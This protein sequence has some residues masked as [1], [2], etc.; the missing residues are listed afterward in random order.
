M[1]LVQRC[2]KDS[3]DRTATLRKLK[4]KRGAGG[5]DMSRVRGLLAVSIGVASGGSVQ[6]AVAC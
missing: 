6:R 2:K 4:Q 1:V 3:Y 5:N